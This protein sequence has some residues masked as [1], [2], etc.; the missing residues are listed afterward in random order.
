MLC[1]ACC[2]FL[3]LHAGIGAGGDGPQLLFHG[4]AD[5]EGVDEA[6]DGSS[7]DTLIGTCECLKGFIGIGIC[8]ATEDG[9]DAF[10]ND[11]PGIVQVLLQLLLIEDELAQ[12][13]EG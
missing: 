2:C 13:L 9:L 1:F 7:I 6:S 10:G 4:I 11:S 3:S 5:I 12:P 8:L